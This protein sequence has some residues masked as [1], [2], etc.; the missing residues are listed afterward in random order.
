M[1]SYK[2]AFSFSTS[3][4]KSENLELQKF[5]RFI[6]LIEDLKIKERF[7]NRNCLTITITVR[8]IRPEGLRN[9][10]T[11]LLQKNDLHRIKQ[12]LL[13]DWEWLVKAEYWPLPITKSLNFH[14][15]KRPKFE[16]KKRSISMTIWQALGR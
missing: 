11:V 16:L 14:K 6:F 12:M 1:Y 2:I 8:I 3:N 13:S 7:V 10:C 5:S 9:C 4:S 15:F